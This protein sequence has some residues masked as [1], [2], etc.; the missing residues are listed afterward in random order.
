MQIYE[1]K[2]YQNE[3]GHEIQ[4]LKLISSNTIKYVIPVTI[5]T[6]KGPI[7]RLIEI[8]EAKNIADAFLQRQE[9]MDKFQKNLEEEIRKQQL[10][11]PPTAAE[12]LIIKP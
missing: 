8:K 6:M 11:K 12:Q 2:F 1:I 4:E 9:T 7:Q 10:T 5:M 3:D